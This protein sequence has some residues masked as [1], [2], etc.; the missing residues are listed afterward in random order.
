MAQ[1]LLKVEAIPW[2]RD[3]FYISDQ[4]KAPYGDTRGTDTVNP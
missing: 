2:L 3:R 1:L 4:H